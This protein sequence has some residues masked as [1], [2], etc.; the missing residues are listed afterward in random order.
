MLKLVRRAYAIFKAYL[1][2]DVIRSMGFIYG[3]IGFSIW[4]VLFIAPMSLFIE[5]NVDPGIVAS[6]GFTAI[7]IF[8][9]YSIATWD[10]AAELRYMIN[11]GI[12]EYYIASGSGFLPHYLGILPVSMIWLLIALTINYLLLSILFKPPALAIN[13]PY[14]L[15]LGLVMLFLV[16]IAYALILGGSMIATG[17]TGFIM[18]L[19]GFILPIATGGL[20]PLSRLPEPLRIFALA[21][22][23]SYPA[24]VI[25]Y[26]ILGWTPIHELHEILL[27]GFSYAIVF[28]LVAI[29]YF[30]YQLKKIL[31]EGVRVTTMW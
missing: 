17:T 24:E 26:A 25:R 12:L 31:R 18:E 13:D 2:S 10:W 6:Y 4:I 11:H 23:F 8:M 5:S 27:I 29:V 1:V 20:T 16:L 3:M 30:K 19:L 22:P 15:V 14:V 28:I 21:T 7:F 9:M